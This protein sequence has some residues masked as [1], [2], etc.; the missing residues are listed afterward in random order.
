MQREEENV[1]TDE[2]INEYFLYFEKFILTGFLF[3]VENVGNIKSRF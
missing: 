2:E 3:Y 1:I